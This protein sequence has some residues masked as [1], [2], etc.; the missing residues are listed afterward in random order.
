MHVICYCAKT[1]TGSVLIREPSTGPRYD[2][3][4]ISLTMVSMHGE[5]FITSHEEKKGICGMEGIPV[6]TYST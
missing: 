5:S 4:R 6:D 1:R 3:G 2:T